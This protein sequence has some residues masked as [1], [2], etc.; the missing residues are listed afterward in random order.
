[1]L[2]MKQK[3]GTRYLGPFTLLCCA[4]SVMGFSGPGVL[5]SGLRTEARRI[6][7]SSHSGVILHGLYTVRML[8]QAEVDKNMEVIEA[9]KALKV[10]TK[11]FKAIKKPSGALMA[12]PEYA[13]NKDA[14]D[15]S[16]S[17][18]YS[19]WSANQRRDKRAVIVI[20]TTNPSA[21]TDLELMVKEQQVDIPTSQS[22]TGA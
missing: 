11:V 18:D 20:D 7:A 1:M 12:L 19:N 16:R 9:G 6:C 8:D 10:G 21:M 5:P 15:E 22:E 14:A 2:M 17:A 13:R 4:L 3:C